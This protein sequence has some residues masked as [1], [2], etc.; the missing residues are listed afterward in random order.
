MYLEFDYISYSILEVLAERE[1]KK[2][3]PQEILDDLRENKNICHD[4]FDFTLEEVSFGLGA[5]KTYR[6]FNYETSYDDNVIYKCKKFKKDAFKVSYDGILAFRSYKAAR[7]FY[8]SGFKDATIA[9]RISEDDEYIDAL[10][11]RAWCCHVNNEFAKI[12][13]RQNKKNK[14]EMI[15][16]ESLDEGDNYD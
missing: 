6:L 1:G 15:L 4:I 11:S 5:Q 2:F 10:A 8:I 12:M 3:Y 9:A 13:A 14:S 16:N 7:E